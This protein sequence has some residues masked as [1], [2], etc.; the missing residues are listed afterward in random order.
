MYSEDFFQTQHTKMIVTNSLP[1]S[2]ENKNNN[3]KNVGAWHLRK[4]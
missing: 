4:I 1:I 3:K 2:Y